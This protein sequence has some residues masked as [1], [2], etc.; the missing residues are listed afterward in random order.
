MDALTASL[1]TVLVRLSLLP[2]SVPHEAAHHAEHLLH[3]L[4]PD[5]EEAVV[6]YYG[7][8]GAEQL[9]LAEIA[10]SRSLADED[11]M[12]RIDSCL[13]RLA[14]TPEWQV[15]RAEIPRQVE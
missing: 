8:F 3:L 7:L 4:P 15:I 11:M 9:S 5:D 13:R 10:R 1:N 2:A 12:A 14:V 6:A